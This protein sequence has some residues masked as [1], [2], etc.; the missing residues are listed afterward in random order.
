MNEQ[1]S[2][3]IKSALFFMMCGCMLGI[4]GFIFLFNDIRTTTIL[5]TEVSNTGEV[6]P[7]ENTKTGDRQASIQPRAE[8][9]E[10]KK[11]DWGSKSTSSKWKEF[12]YTGTI[13]HKWFATGDIRQEY[14]N[15]A[16]KIGWENLLLLN[17]CENW[18][19]DLDLQSR[20][21]QLGKREQ[22]YWLCQLQIYHYKDIDHKRFLTDYKY[23]L[24]VCWKKRSTG[25]PF[26]WPTRIV[27]GQYCY[28]AVKNRFIWLK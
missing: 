21:S 16:Y 26:Y 2:N 12:T 19:W 1:N 25:T 18:W 8:I 9:R 4:I 23:Q 6:R 27:K 20:C 3:K 10:I 22:S 7:I 14:V 17:E 11:S 24:D 13:I 28:Q 15:Y 5:Y